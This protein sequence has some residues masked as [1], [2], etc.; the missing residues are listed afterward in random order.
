MKEK[1]ESRKR[2][3]RH[4]KENNDLEAKPKSELQDATRLFNVGILR[5]RRQRDAGIFDEEV[6]QITGAVDAIARVR[7]VQEVVSFGPRLQLPTLTHI[8]VLEQSQVELIQPGADQRVTRR[9]AKRRIEDLGRARQV[10]NVADLR[11]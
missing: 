4:C 3:S 6:R 5:K 8:Y 2:L 1:R 7:M 10:H 9:S 11:R